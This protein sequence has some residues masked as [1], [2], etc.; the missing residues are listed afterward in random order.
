M[1]E[2]LR[3]Y[4]C[5]AACQCLLRKT[6]TEKSIPQI[7]LCKYVGMNSDVMDERAL[8]N[9]IISRQRLFKMQSRL[10]KPAGKH[11]VYSRGQ[12]TQN[13]AGRVVPLTAQ[14]QQILVQALGQVQLAAVRVIT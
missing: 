10:S 8:G 13:E 11:Q 9:G 12:V 2:P 1:S 14:T 6:E 3:L 7:R 5:V 4:I